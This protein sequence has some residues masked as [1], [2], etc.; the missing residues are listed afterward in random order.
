MIQV[1]FPGNLY[2]RYGATNSTVPMIAPAGMV[3]NRLFSVL[4]PKLLMMIGMKL[5]T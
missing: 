5:L 3:N 2:A 4:N 1:L